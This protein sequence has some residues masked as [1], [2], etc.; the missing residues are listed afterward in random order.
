MAGSMGLKGL[1][2]LLGIWPLPNSNEVPKKALN[3][4]WGQGIGMGGRC[5]IGQE[6]IKW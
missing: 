2:A 6:V 3:S 5:L 1:S 4:I